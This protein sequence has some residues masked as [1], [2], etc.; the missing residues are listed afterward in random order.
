MFSIYPYAVHEARIQAEVRARHR[1]YADADE[2]WRLLELAEITSIRQRRPQT[3]ML[4][5]AMLRMHHWLAALLR[6]ARPLRPGP[7]R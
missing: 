4:S 6:P 5:Q 3:P 1:A 7:V 2:Q